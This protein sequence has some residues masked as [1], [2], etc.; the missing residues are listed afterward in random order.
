M[1]WLQFERYAVWGLGR[2][3][4]A[5]SNLLA[6]RDKDVFASDICAE[7]DF[8]GW[9]QLDTDVETHFGS[10]RLADAEVLVLSP[11]LSPHLPAVEH[12]LNSDL[13]VISEI[14]LA[15]AAAPEGTEFICITGTDGKTT[16]TGLV[17][18]ILEEAGIDRSVGG[19]IGTPLS[20]V[21]RDLEGRLVV[22]EISASQMWASPE[23]SPSVSAFTNLAVDHTDYF[24]SFSTYAAAKKKMLLQTPNDAVAVFNANDS[25][26]RKW[27]DEFD[28]QTWFFRCGDRPTTKSANHRV[29]GT[30]H[31]IAIES[32]YAKDRFEVA[33]RY[34]TGAHNLENIMCATA[35]ALTYGATIDN[36]QNAVRRFRPQSHRH[37]YVGSFGGI[38]VIDDS[39]ATNVNAAL[40]G[41]RAVE[42]DVVPIMGGKDKGLNLT[43]L[44]DYLQERRCPVVLLGAIADRFEKS[45]RDAGVDS[46]RIHRTDTM[47]GAVSTAFELAEP[48]ST[49]ILSPACSSFDMFDNYKHRGR[50]FQRAVRERAQSSKSSSRKPTT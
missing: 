27:A 19:N 30:G 1:D 39:K 11:G 24:E 4:I 28:G 29:W 46:N 36:V 41:L 33:P 18:A 7:S 35:T 16:T 49:I 25:R 3:G 14:E 15:H 40:P 34:L 17:G 5:A 50:V 38:D 2:S 21:I 8:S 23:L 20:R 42:G 22:A 31:Q 9:N 44:A 13:Y 43:P 32:E 6:S 45:L 12:A 47:D 10:N 26:F 37:E 48:G